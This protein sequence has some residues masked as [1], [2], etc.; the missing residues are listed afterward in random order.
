MASGGQSLFEDIFEVQEVD[1]Q[2]KKFDKGERT[3]THTHTHTETHT[4]SETRERTHRH[5]QNARACG[6]AQ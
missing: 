2:G 3:Y 6:R 5:G 4:L 1:P